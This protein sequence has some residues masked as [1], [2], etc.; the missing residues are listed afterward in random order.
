MND[1]AMC[2]VTLKDRKRTEE[3]QDCLVLECIS[4]VMRGGRLRWF[5]HVE[6]KDRE[7]WMS[8]FEDRWCQR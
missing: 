5:G 3:L 7:K 2:G 1:D 8:K 6:R 4:D